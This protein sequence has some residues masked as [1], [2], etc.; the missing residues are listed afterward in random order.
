MAHGNNMDLC[1]LSTDIADIIVSSNFPCTRSTIIPGIIVDSFIGEESTNLTSSEIFIFH[2][3]Q[4][5]MIIF[6]I[7]LFIILY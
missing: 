3:C 5:P 7:K 2:I 6:V 4:L 1:M